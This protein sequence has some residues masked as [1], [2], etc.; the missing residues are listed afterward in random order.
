MQEDEKR[1]N[2]IGRERLSFEGNILTIWFT[3]ISAKVFL[4]YNYE[5]SNKKIG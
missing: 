4:N 5:I 1:V 3:L 2:P